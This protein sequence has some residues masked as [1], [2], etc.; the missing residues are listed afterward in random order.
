[1][2][3]R[4]DVTAEYMARARALAEAVDIGLEVR[5]ALRSTP[6]PYDALADAHAIVKDMALAP[7]LLATPDPPTIERLAGL[8]SFFFNYWNTVSGEHVERFWQLVAEHGLPFQ[9]RDVVAREVLNRGRIR[10]VFEYQHVTAG[11]MILRQMG[12]IS[13]EEADRLNVMLK[14]FEGT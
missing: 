6:V 7:E 11:L 8:E 13:G 10:D 3:D 9:R 1:V 12:R 5:A 14:Q 2:P 4:H